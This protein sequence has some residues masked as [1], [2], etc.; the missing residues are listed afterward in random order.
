MIG[1]SAVMPF[2]AIISNNNYIYENSFL[3]FIYDVLNFSNNIDFILFFGICLIGFYIIRA[4]LTMVYFY[5]I[6]KFARGKYN[7]I[8]KEIFQKIL[9]MK[10]IDFTN[11]KSS[12]YSKSIINEAYN[13]T[14]VIIAFLNIITEVFVIVLIY[15]LM[16]YVNFE[17]TMLITSILV[18]S[19]LFLI[20]VVSKKIKKAGVQRDIS[21]KSFYD[22]ITNTFGSYKLIKLSINNVTNIQ[23]RFTN[24]SI[25]FTNSNIV[26]ETISQ[27]PRVFLESITF[28]MIIVIVLFL[29]F[30]SY[31]NLM[32]KVPSLTLI[33]LGLYRLMPSA[34]R[35]LTSYG[36]II[37]AHR[38]LDI[39]YEIYQCNAE[40]FS[41]QKEID[42]KTNLE[43]RNLTFG[44]EI[45]KP[46]LKSINLSINKGEKVAFVGP[47]GSGK[48]SMVDILC[49]LI[50]I[51]KNILFVD[52]QEINDSNILSLRNKIGYI[53]QNVYLFDGTVAENICLGNKR[54][55]EKII[56]VLKKANI[57]DLLLTKEG[58]ETEVGDSGVKLSGGQKQRIAIAR[59]L[60]MDPEI[61]VLDEATSA[62]DETTEQKIM[63]EIL[64]VSTDKTLIMI[65]HRLKTIEHCD[66]VYELKN[67]SI[68]RKR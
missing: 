13:F 36:Q 66:S 57:Y 28:I 3:K 14:T 22:I 27:L 52:N 32:D 21:Q 6:S 41:H 47:S 44:Y 39:I 48:S 29:V 46:I 63:D 19:M 30:T 15:S 60:Y 2:I 61:L 54:D 31:E 68:R 10:Y 58:L 49:G 53:P 62:L 24:S 8:S 64:K 25:N 40:Q 5:V 7:A 51:N 56:D 42:F 11:V 26:S 65:A 55:D 16:F 20:K 12:H 35:L 1:I 33:L 67:G 59:A 45:E 23:N 9:N 34:N 37:Y 38:S 4:I 50:T 43:L 17:L 18:V